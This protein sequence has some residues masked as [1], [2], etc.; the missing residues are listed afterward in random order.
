MDRRDDFEEY[1]TRFPGEYTD[2]D[3]ADFGAKYESAYAALEATPTDEERQEQR[4]PECSDDGIT[5]DCGHFVCMQ[6]LHD[7]YCAEVAATH[8]SEGCDIPHCDTCNRC[9]DD[10]GVHYP[11]NN[12]PGTF[13][14]DCCMLFSDE[15][16]TCSTY[17]IA[18]S[19]V[20][21]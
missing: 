2:E 5:Q 13:C 19:W 7:H 14:G 17:L 6:H 3:I 12:G 20:A 16:S 10:E 1:S 8:P 18:P 4:C 9:L 11:I 21:V 15:C